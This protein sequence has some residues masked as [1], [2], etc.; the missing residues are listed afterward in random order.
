MDENDSWM[1]RI[2]DSSSSYPS[3]VEQ[4]PSFENPPSSSS[5]PGNPLNVSNPWIVRKWL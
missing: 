3:D 2:L 5:T 4:S 1:V